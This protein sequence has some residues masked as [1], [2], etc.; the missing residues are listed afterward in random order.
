M[1]CSLAPRRWDV[2]GSEPLRAST[3]IG[4]RLPA[5]MCDFTV[6]GGAKRMPTEPENIDKRGAIRVGN[7]VSF[8]SRFLA[9]ASVLRCAGLPLR[10]RVRRVRILADI[11]NQLVHTSDVD[12]LRVDRQD[13]RRRDQA[14]KRDHLLR[15]V[16]RPLLRHMGD[17]RRTDEQR[18][19]VAIR[20]ATLQLFEPD[21]AGGAGAVV[22]NDGLAEFPRQ[23]FGRGAARGVTRSAAANPTIR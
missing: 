7:S 19:G 1:S 8:R 16:E 3:A 22:D 18:D 10:R 2:F 23:G 17:G 13:D 6:A 20:R 9:S 21:H 12:H 11:G 14:S 4:R 15:E 5:S